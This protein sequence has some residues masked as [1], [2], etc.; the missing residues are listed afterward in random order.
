MPEPDA[1]I[2]DPAVLAE[3][4]ESVGGDRAFV[5]DL[6]E[7]YLADGT[8]QLSDIEGA[9]ATN[10]AVAIVR[11]AHTLKSSSATVGA[12]QL[13]AVARGVEVAGRSGSLDGLA[14]EIDAGTLH[15]AWDRAAA[16]LRGWIEAGETS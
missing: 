2:L 11:P 3:L 5:V 15:D 13:A 10:D 14:P 9:F 7:T 8:T 16:A 1:P 4:A 6:V 12:M